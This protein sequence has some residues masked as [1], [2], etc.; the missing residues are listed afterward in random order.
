VCLITSAAPPLVVPRV[1]AT[2][3]G[4][5]APPA[6]QSSASLDERTMSS[7]Q[8]RA[9]DVKP[10]MSSGR[11]QADD[12]KRT[13]SSGRLTI[14]LILL[15][16]RTGI[17]FHGRPVS[18][19]S[20][21]YS[22][23]PSRRL[24]LSAQRGAE[25]PTFGPERLWL[26]GKQVRPLLRATPPTTIVLD[27]SRPMASMNCGAVVRDGHNPGPTGRGERRIFAG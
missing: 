15:F 12:V 7:E 8:C 22:K 27:G 1:C 10:T 4:Q 17:T 6:T 14:R 13:T 25:D 23:R 24:P 18:R 16:P 26:L 11:R 21:V 2:L 5:P 3:F 20:D 9:D 19:N